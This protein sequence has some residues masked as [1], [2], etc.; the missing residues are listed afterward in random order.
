MSA[1]AQT[2]RYTNRHG[3]AWGTLGLFALTGA[4]ASSV[5][6]HMHMEPAVMVVGLDLPP[7]P[8]LVITNRGRTTVGFEWWPEPLRHCSVDLQCPAKAASG[9][10]DDPSPVFD[11]SCN[12]TWESEWIAL[13]PGA[14]VRWPLDLSR[15][16]TIPTTGADD[17]VVTID[18]MVVPRSK[19]RPDD[20]ALQ[21][22]ARPLH[23]ELRVTLQAAPSDDATG[24]NSH[25]GGP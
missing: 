7:A 13:R 19:R 5:T 16:C 2:R 21:R 14:S 22:A 25:R 20:E 23:R 10:P 15:R 8:T 17:V 24:V 9:E 4:C 18:V 6:L 11:L 3:L 12:G 1:D